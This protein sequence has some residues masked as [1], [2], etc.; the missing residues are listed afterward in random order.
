MISYNLADD[1]INYAATTPAAAR[2]K[3][4]EEPHFHPWRWV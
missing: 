3:E 2:A 1:N 4:K